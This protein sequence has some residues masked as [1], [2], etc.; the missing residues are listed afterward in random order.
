M[1]ATE[2]HNG[3][4]IYALMHARK[5]QLLFDAMK[6]AV[7]RTPLYNEPQLYVHERWAACKR[8]PDVLDP[9]PY[10]VDIRMMYEHVCEHVHRL[11]SY[12]ESALE[13]I[14]RL[15]QQVARLEAVVTT[16]AKVKFT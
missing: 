8:A 13:R 2:P 15:E 14:E 12:V 9:D 3:M 16:T 5:T 4:I 1:L 10:C 7:E 6:R 11:A